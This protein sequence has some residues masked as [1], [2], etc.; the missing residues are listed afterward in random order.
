MPWHETIFNLF[1]RMFPGMASRIRSYKRVD[2]NTIKMEVDNHFELTFV[3]TSPG[4]WVLMCDKKNARHPR[5]EQP[6]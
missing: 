4:K 5:S 1:K 2:A 6:S 3:Y